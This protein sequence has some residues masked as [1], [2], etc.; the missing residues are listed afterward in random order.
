MK[1]RKE[2]GFTPMVA[3]GMPAGSRPS[4][5]ART[6]PSMA[7]ADARRRQLLQLAAGGLLAGAMTP[8]AGRASA[9]EAVSGKAAAKLGDVTPL[10]DA[11]PDPKALI[12][13]GWPAHASVLMMLGATKRIAA[14]V[15]APKQKPWM[16]QVAPSLNNA[17]HA[18]KGGFVAESLLARNITLA[19][20]T[21]SD[22]AANELQA[23]GIQVVKTV[24]QDF[25]SMRDSIALTAK[26][27][28]NDAPERA[29]RYLQHLDE[30]LAEVRRISSGIPEAKRPRVLHIAQWEPQLLVDGSN[31]I[32]DE[33][34]QAAGGINAAA[35]IE[36][37]LRPV[38][39]EQLLAWDPDVI[40]ESA[41][42]AGQKK[43]AGFAQ[44]GSV[45][46]GRLHTNPEGVFPWDRYGCEITLQLRWALSRLHPDKL[47]ADD[48]LPARVQAFYRQF[49]DYAL[50]EADAR[51]MLQGQPPAKG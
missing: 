22:P 3:S 31:T 28:G 10:A 1:D 5:A 37:S 46:A 21:P 44:L 6:A 2:D 48:D 36:G 27:L 25:A 30:A 32:I 51:R 35:S 4:G 49:F 12:A 41:S 19:F 26:V 15:N 13:N 39:V 9:K 18:P 11:A 20:L 40:I 38:S 24:F 43:A 50:S 29:Q 14:T 8:W 33:W 34:I 42:S 7:A 16:Y 17:I 23:A 47:S 45:R